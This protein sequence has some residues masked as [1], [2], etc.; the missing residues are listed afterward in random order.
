MIRFLGLVFWASIAGLLA[1]AFVG[2]DLTVS[3]RIWLT[4]F[5]CW[6]AGG[7]LARLFSDVNLVPARFRLLVVGKDEVEETR[8]VLTDFRSLESLLLRSRENER[9]HRQQLRPRL[10]ALAD[11]F[12]LLHH[13]INRSEQ[14]ALAATVL[15]DVA[16]LLDDDGSGSAPTLEEIDRFLD[17]ILPN[18]KP[19]NTNPTTA[20]PSATDSITTERT[21][22]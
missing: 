5:V 19:S 18:E 4:A 2:E 22:A 3:M 11:H 7:L 14:P 13:G 16:W 15:G 12:L 9:T 10:T 8:Q 20:N 21:T 17:R 1:A 6:F